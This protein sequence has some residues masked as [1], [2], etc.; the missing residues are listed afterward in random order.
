M[1]NIDSII[2]SDLN[3]VRPM[4]QIGTSISY[5]LNIESFLPLRNIVYQLRMYGWCVVVTS[6]TTISEIKDSFLG[7]G[8]LS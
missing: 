7:S 4:N 8:G 3:L 5:A 1:P 6:I 2:T